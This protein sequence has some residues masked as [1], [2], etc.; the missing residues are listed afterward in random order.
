MRQDTEAY[1]LLLRQR[2]TDNADLTAWLTRREF[3][4]AEVMDKILAARGDDAGRFIGGARK[5]R[6]MFTQM[7]V[8]AGV[9]TDESLAALEAQGEEAA[10]K[11]IT[12]DKLIPK[13]T[14]SALK[15][16]GDSSPVAFLKVALRDMITPRP[17]NSPEARAKYVAAA[18][19]VNNVFDTPFKDTAA[20]LRDL[21][22]RYFYRVAK[23][24]PDAVIVTRE[25]M[26]SAVPAGTR[27]YDT[28]SVYAA[29]HRFPHWDNIGNHYV[30][31]K[32]ERTY[33][34]HRGETDEQKKNR[35]SVEK[36]LGSRFYD[37]VEQGVRYY[38]KT[39]WDEIVAASRKIPPD[40]WAWAATARGEEP[41]AV[42]ED[43]RAEPLT[44]EEVI[45]PPDCA[46]MKENK[47]NV[48]S[49]YMYAWAYKNL[50]PK[51]SLGTK[52]ARAAYEN[53]L[54]E[55]DRLTSDRT[56]DRTDFANLFVLRRRFYYMGDANK[57]ERDGSL[58]P[59][60]RLEDKIYRAA[61]QYTQQEGFSRKTAME[62][63]QML[64]DYVSEELGVP[65]KELLSGVYYAQ[66]SDA[67]RYYRI[68]LPAEDVAG[69]TEERKAMDATIRGVSEDLYNF[70]SGQW[71]SKTDKIYRTKAWRAGWHD[72]EALCAEI[73][74]GAAGK[75]SKG[76]GRF[77]EPHRGVI[78]PRVGPMVPGPYTSDTIREGTG[79]YGIEYG[80]WMNE[81]DRDEAN[82][83][84]AEALH[85][86]ADVLGVP[87]AA[88]SLGKRLA[89]ALGARGSGKASA[90]YEPWSKAINMTRTMGS[91]ALAHEWGHALDHW[92]A[93]AGQSRRVV[94]GKLVAYFAT[95]LDG[96]GGMQG[97]DVTPEERK[98]VNDALMRVTDI[99]LAG[100]E[101][102]N[103]A[104]ARRWREENP[105]IPQPKHKHDTGAYSFD[106]EFKRRV[107]L[108]NYYGRLPTVPPKPNADWRPGDA[109]HVDALYRWDEENKAHTERARAFD[110]TLQKNAASNTMLKAAEVAGEYWKRNE[111]MFARAWESF[112][113]DKLEKEKRNSGYLVRGTKGHPVYPAGEQRER[114]YGEFTKFLDTLRPIL[115]RIAVRP[116]GRGRTRRP[117]CVAI[118]PK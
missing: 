7:L 21:Q 81:A 64:L 74:K 52:A 90:H 99:L 34:Y 112:V 53:A 36:P 103:D 42:P 62:K 22:L 106:W 60:H 92:L 43:E 39:K 59:T 70:L 12:R 5:D 26:R 31:T 80:N 9:V 44:R 20:F 100:K 79:L 72:V 24:D 109:E 29:L 95:M 69:L 25:E 104:R 28:A 6:G 76:G 105:D 117:S 48:S 93:D 116:N 75:G 107:G 82:K 18:N 102:Y 58:L 111:E 89:L 91:G 83:S 78:G 14:P 115:R 45:D 37:A 56:G 23:G 15:T 114:L 35:E 46:Q 86:L 88:V 47:E 19:A 17:Y 33:R 2:A 97:V 67:P 108:D 8:T 73:A 38:G 101:G 40:D 30:F 16:L 10:Y 87:L 32:K 11:E 84:V 54:G 113:L 4:I 66:G 3:S 41:V 85:D 51:K 96:T 98:T 49:A 65:V 13:R 63:H 68:P 110:T 77:T 61:K 50:V 27:D 55:F 57:D 118:K 71:D 94:N 1:L